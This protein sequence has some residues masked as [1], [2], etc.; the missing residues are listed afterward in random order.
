MLRKLLITITFVVLLSIFIYPQKNIVSVFRMTDEPI[1]VSK[2]HYGQSLI[3]EI[4][5][6]HDGLPEWLQSISA[7][8][9]ILMLDADW[10]D[11]SPKLVEVIQKKNIPTGLLG[12][13]GNE[14]YNIDELKKE[15]EIYEK[16]FNKKPLWFMT[17]DYE[18]TPE[19]KQA[20]FNEEINLLSPS[21]IYGESNQYENI[22]GAII[23]VHIHE[24][25]KP[26]FE[27]LT[28][29]VK[30]NKFVSL[31]ENIFGYTIKS[32]KRP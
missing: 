28:T 9:P 31:E 11:R 23:S 3:I 29:F 2:G 14:E 18:Y 22:K 6:T 21:H 7:P 8:Y 27:S 16:H 25:S 13:H 32:T 19:L 1:V 30:G 15:V 24:E 12:K 17:R 20:V 4:S 10:I 26:N 5:F